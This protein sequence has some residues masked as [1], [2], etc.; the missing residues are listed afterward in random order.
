MSEVGVVQDESGQVLD[1]PV[2]AIDDPVS[3]VHRM[4]GLKQ[5]TG[6][7]PPVLTENACDQSTLLVRRH[8]LPLVC[9]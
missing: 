8:R 1:T 2:D 7:V 5:S 9:G 3:A 6:E 4:S